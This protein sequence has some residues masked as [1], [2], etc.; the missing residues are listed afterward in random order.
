MAFVDS[1]LDFAKH[2]FRLFDIDTDDLL[3]CIN[4]EFK[5]CKSISD[6]SSLMS[7]FS[8]SK[9]NDF[10]LDITCNISRFV[11]FCYTFCTGSTA[12]SVLVF[13]Y[14]YSTN[15]SNLNP[16]GSSSLDLISF[17][18][19]LL[20]QLRYNSN[21]ICSKFRFKLEVISP[22][23]QLNTLRCFAFVYDSVT[24]TLSTCKQGLQNDALY[25]GICLL[26][27]ISG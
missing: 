26:F 14:N 9:N 20:E 22:V 13:I 10:G 11:I 4:K 16:C 21:L 23:V 12:C 17:Y 5:F 8:N 3:I 25:L 15:V 6:I 7:W 27:G 19:Y 18:S 24:Q 1:L 2:M